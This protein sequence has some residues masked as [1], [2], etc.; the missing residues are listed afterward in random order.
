MSASEDPSATWLRLRNN[1][2]MT[3]LFGATLDPGSGSEEDSIK[4]SQQVAVATELG[5]EDAQML[6]INLGH[7]DCCDIPASLVRVATCV[8]GAKWYIT[9]PLVQV[10]PT[11]RMF[12]RG[13]IFSLGVV[14]GRTSNA[15]RELDAGAGGCGGGTRV[16]IWTDM[17]RATVYG[18]G[19][20]SC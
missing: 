4:S 6:R 1:L 13:A 17:A 20:G 14:W 12:F 15:Y 19:L 10:L 8:G 7:G 16:P 5:K 18:Q 11:A 3:D 9:T 2:G